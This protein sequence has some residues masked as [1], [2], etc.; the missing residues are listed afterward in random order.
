MRA[1]SWCV[2]SSSLCLCV[3]AA[4]YKSARR[5]SFVVEENYNIVG[6]VGDQWSDLQGPYTGFKVK[7]PNYLYFLA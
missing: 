2:R 3:Q 6:C 5:T 4:E 7:I 1:C